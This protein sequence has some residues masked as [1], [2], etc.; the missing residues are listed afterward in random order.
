MGPEKSQTVWLLLDCGRPLAG[1]LPDGRTRL[2]GAVDACLALARAAARGGDRVGLLAFGAEVRA[3]V[4]PRRGSAQLGPVAAALHGLEP[5]PEET[6]VVGA[7]DLVE[8]HQPRRA[9]VVLLTD[10]SDPESS[11]ALV[12]RAALLRH[13]H[14]VSVVAAAH[15][16]LLAAASR[17]PHSADDAY[18]RIAAERILAERGL[19]LRRLRSAGIRVDDV[20]ADRL[21]AAAVGGYLAAKGSGRL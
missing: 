4:L 2:D 20:P 7:I 9:L 21:R 16:D 18:A 1:R 10:V 5:R 17:R 8:A 6:D 14:L 19:A 12:A 3:L 15:P 11:T 13:R